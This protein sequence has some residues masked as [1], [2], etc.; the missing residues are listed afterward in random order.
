MAVRKPTTITARLFATIPLT[1]FKPKVN[2]SAV[3]D[4]RGKLILGKIRRMHRHEGC[5]K[6]ASSCKSMPDYYEDDY[7]EQ[8]RREINN[9]TH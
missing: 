2:F 9:I 3:V 1:L 6:I 5:T 7:I 4:S 8:D